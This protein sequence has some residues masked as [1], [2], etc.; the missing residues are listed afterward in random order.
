MYSISLYTLSFLLE[1]FYSFH[2]V[3]PL[4][5]CSPFPIGLS[6][7]SHLF[8]QMFLVHNDVSSHSQF[9]PEIFPFIYFP[10]HS[11]FF[12]PLPTPEAVSLVPKWDVNEM[13]MGCMR[14]VTS[15]LQISGNFGQS[16]M[17]TSHL[18]HFPPI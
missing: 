16:G 14:D 13:L 11:F 7:F 5:L 4:S 2:S 3:F 15:Q 1:F 6:F 9:L 8:K 10:F 17:L 12:L 18:V